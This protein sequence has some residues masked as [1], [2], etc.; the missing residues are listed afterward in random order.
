MKIG[1]LLKLLN[2]KRVNY[3]LIG[4]QACAAHGHVRATQDI[5]ILIEPS[6]QN[7]EQLR[8]A[9]EEFGYDT[10]G[11]SLEDF[12]TKKILFRKY[13]L[14]TD[15]HPSAEGVDT[16][17]A[18]KNKIVGKCEGVDTYFVSL[19][20]LIRMKK[21]AGRPKDKEDL[22]YLLEIRRQLKMKNKKKK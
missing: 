19:K 9:L 11:A 15:I 18:L 6:P 17:T 7:I 14:D 3:V 16:E 10:F 8:K 1:R 22:R 12:Q 2:E 21:A 4:A 13:W 5:D 20:D